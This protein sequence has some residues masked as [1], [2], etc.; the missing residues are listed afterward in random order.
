M[1]YYSDQINKTLLGSHHQ[2]LT[3]NLSQLKV[4]VSFGKK[5]A[6]Y[7]HVDVNDNFF[8]NIYSPEARWDTT[9]QSWLLMKGIKVYLTW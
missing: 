3:S 4:L 7:I 8:D 9:V 5:I 6:A 1:T 2:Y